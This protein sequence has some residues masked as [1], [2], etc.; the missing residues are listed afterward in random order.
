VETNVDVLALVAASLPL[1]FDEFRIYGPDLGP[2]DLPVLRWSQNQWKENW[3][4]V[5]RRNIRI[6]RSEENFTSGAHRPRIQIDLHTTMV[7]ASASASGRLWLTMDDGALLVYARASGPRWDEWLGEAFAVSSQRPATFDCTL[8]RRERSQHLQPVGDYMLGDLVGE[9]GYAKVKSGFSVKTGERVA[10]K[11]MLSSLRVEATREILA[12]SALKHRNIVELQDVIEAGGYTYLVMELAKGGELLAKLCEIDRFTE[13]EA[14]FYW[15]Q[16]LQ[17]VLY[18]H[19]KGLC[20]PELK[21][22]NLLLDDKEVVLKITGFGTRH[23]MYDDRYH[24]NHSTVVTV[25]P[26]LL[27]RSHDVDGFIAD[28]WSCGVILY[29]M[30]VGNY[31]FDLGLRI[32][33]RYRDTYDMVKKAQYRLPS[34]ET[35]GPVICLVWHDLVLR[36]HCKA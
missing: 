17:G 14:R 30:V 7:Q 15:Q 36:K 26:E 6:Y 2:T 25:A 21:L 22:E 34:C 31:P 19:R 29:T 4:V 11:I 9:G 23:M 16:L 5:D 32:G 20:H 27:E 3:L 35:V 10:A 13:E 12:M 28:V 24:K 1:G 18:C 33:R 8:C